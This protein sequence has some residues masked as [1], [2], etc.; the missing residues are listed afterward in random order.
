M[1]GLNQ[2]VFQNSDG[3]LG[4]YRVAHRDGRIDVEGQL[5]CP[6]LLVE[7]QK[8]VQK[9]KRSSLQEGFNDASMNQL[10]S[11]NVSFCPFSASAFRTLLYRTMA[12]R[13]ERTGTSDNFVE[14]S[15]SD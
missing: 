9:V 2:C 14:F 11:G 5:T 12:G 10:E 8:F 1:I 6:V 7:E 13:E 3:F 15:I 4:Q